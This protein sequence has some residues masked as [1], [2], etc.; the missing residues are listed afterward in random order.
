V[1]IV[2]TATADSGQTEPDTAT[3][4][5]PLVLSEQCHPFTLVLDDLSTAAI[6]V[7]VVDN[8]PAGTLTALG[9]STHADAA[10]DLGNIFYNGPAGTFTTNRT[11]AL[12][13]PEVGSPT[14]P[15]IRINSS[16]LGSTPGTLLILATDTCIELAAGQYVL[17]TPLG[18]IAGGTVAISETLDPANAPFSS[19]GTTNSLGPLGSGA[20]SQSASAPLSLASPGVVSLSKRITIVHTAAAQLTTLAAGGTVWA[21]AAAAPPGEAAASEASAHADDAAQEPTHGV[22]GEAAVPQLVEGR[23]GAEVDFQP[24]RRSGRWRAG[25]EAEAAIDA[26]LAEFD[27]DLLAECLVP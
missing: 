11:T 21:G 23:H 8:M 12:S 17:N 19:N 22:G 7:I 14:E 26:A 1:P 15:E 3:F 16:N 18:G 10:A 9:P 20:F 6:D 4:S 24:Q 25:A 13:D 2:N 5:V 27:E